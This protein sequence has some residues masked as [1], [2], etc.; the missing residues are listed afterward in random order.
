M[1]LEILIILTSLI[2]HELAHLIVALIMGVKFL[3][4]ELLPFGGQAKLQD[5]TGLE[6]SKEIC[7]AI[8][9]P[10]CSLSIS[11]LLYL[12]NLPLHP[13]AIPY[14]IKI[15]L[16]L[17]LFNL[18]PA[19]PLDGGRVFRSLL[20]PIMGFRK[21]TAITANLGKMLALMLVG[22]SLYLLYISNYG[23]NYIVIG[24]LLY[25]AAYR[26]KHLLTFA[27]MRYLINKQ[28]YLGSQGFLAGEQYI[29]KKGSLIKDILY[30]SKPKS[31]ILTFVI[32]DDNNLI[33]VKTEA[34]LIEMLL[35]K[36]PKAR[37]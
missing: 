12:V 15:N 31:Y 25:M 13:E 24:V 27:F 8:A 9:G 4:I 35:E 30:N 18:L 36:G 1:G 10:L 37:I 20:S 22:Y 17:G 11:G 6:P 3:E 28:G 16:L 7:I 14:L 29:S 21:A 34:E 2:L 32:D 5:F 19:L 33:K 23:F 26:E